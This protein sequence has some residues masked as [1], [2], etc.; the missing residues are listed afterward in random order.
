MKAPVTAK[1][2][3]STPESVKAEACPV[4]PVCGAESRT[5]F[6]V[7][8]ASYH[9]CLRKDCRLEFV[10][11]QPPEAELRQAYSKYYGEQSDV[12]YEETPDALYGQILGLVAEA[13]APSKTARLLDVG[14]ATGGLFE[15]LPPAWT[16]GYVGVE[17]YEKA[18]EAARERT[19][20][21][22]LG[23]LDDALGSVPDRWDLAILNQVLEHLRSPIEELRKIRQGCAEDGLIL[24]ATPN[25]NSLKRKLLGAKWSEYRNPTHL[26]AFR[27]TALRTC[28]H[29][30][31]W[32]AVERSKKLLCYPHKGRLGNTAGMALRI[33]GLDGNLTVLA[34]ASEP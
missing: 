22:I 31:G 11:P 6:S 23:S 2:R 15:A 3:A 32:N 20:R 29:R 16:R 26:F 21:P 9:G 19:G 25:V 27:W 8:S 34:R 28:L 17:P 14:C 12:E 5:L 24:V 1:D 4:C 30:A 7:D 18:R 13:L 10:S 33:M